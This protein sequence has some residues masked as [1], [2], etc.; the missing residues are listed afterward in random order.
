MAILAGEYTS[1]LRAAAAA[2][3]GSDSDAKAT[4]ADR[5]DPSPSAVCRAGCSLLSNMVLNSAV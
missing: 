1:E 3:F 2:L 5:V 4:R